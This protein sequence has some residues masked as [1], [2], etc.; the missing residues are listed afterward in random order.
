MI[1]GLLFWMVRRGGL[2]M[3][4]GGFGGGIFGVG[5]SWVKMFNKDE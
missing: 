5:K 4:G 2:V 1:V 3:G